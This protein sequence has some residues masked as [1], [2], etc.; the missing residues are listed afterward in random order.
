[1]ASRNEYSTP[2]FGGGID[3][4][5]IPAA[6]NT[7]ASSNKDRDGTV[8]GTATPM[9][10]HSSPYFHTNT[11]Q[12]NR[13]RRD[14]EQKI[15]RRSQ[16]RTQRTPL[17]FPEEIRPQEHR[18]GEQHNDADV[19][20]GFNM[21]QAIAG[22]LMQPLKVGID[23]TAK[24]TQPTVAM[25]KQALLPVMV[26][27][28]EEIW[29]N[30]APG[31]LQTWMK[32]VPSSLRNV[33]D[34][35][36]ETD[37]GKELGEK[38]LNLGENLVDITSSDA[39]RQCL[40]DFTVLL[41]KLLEALHTPEVKSLLDQAAVEACRIV[42]ALSCGRAKQIWFDLSD[43]IWALIEVGSDPVMVVSLAEWCAQICFALERERESL[44][45]RR[46]LERIQAKRTDRDRRQTK[47]YPPGKAVVGS[48]TVEKAFA[49][50]LEKKEQY[51][52]G[53]TRGQVY[54]RLSEEDS[55][56]QR[57]IVTSMSTEKVDIVGQAQHESS[58]TR[59]ESEVTLNLS[60]E[61]LRNNEEH[62]DDLV[63]QSSAS[64]N[65]DDLACESIDF[66]TA[67]RA[68]LNQTSGNNGEVQEKHVEDEA[69]MHA[70]DES[71]LQF[72]RKL[73]E[74]LLESRK[75]ARFQ[76]YAKTPL[77]QENDHVEIEHE[78]TGNESV[79]PNSAKLVVSNRLLGLSFRWWKLSLA[80]IVTGTVLL[81]IIWFGLGCYGLYALTLSGGDARP[82]PFD[83]GSHLLQPKQPG[84]VIQ[85]NV[86]IQPSDQAAS[87]SVEEWEKMK[88]D[89]DS[90]ISQAKSKQRVVHI[91]PD[92]L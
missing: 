23:T 20:G 90:A 25:T 21:G 87:I 13:I 92:E 35:L 69:E 54:D 19:G 37:S 18:S 72:Y 10:Y 36:L 62:G 58:I 89:V 45:E 26:P 29:K 42:D 14:L 41:I 77:A 78:N 67:I 40:I 66:E 11:P 82:S 59:N 83:L 80:L 27:L 1:M 91:E 76:M 24:L 88:I 49:N 39:A 16:I 38:T 15:R 5:A 22:L 70:F 79:K 43:A 12:R 2:D 65:K 44:N 61:D 48:D 84:V 68:Q 60:I 73:N 4:S 30:Y 85:L 7:V 53:E 34:L 63:T 3:S 86:G 57:V 74:V 6:R 51:R 64:N 33:K 50:T 46:R 52:D 47:T 17:G 32:V 8:S 9:S 75:E 81:S 55:P 56:P 28:F 31:R 71:V